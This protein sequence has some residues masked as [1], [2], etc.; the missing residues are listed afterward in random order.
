MRGRRD[1][2][3]QWLRHDAGI[4]DR[5]LGACARHGG[6]RSRRHPRRRDGARHRRSS[7]QSYASDCWSAAPLTSPA[8]LEDDAPFRSYRGG[9]WT[10]TQL[11]TFRQRAPGEEKAS[12]LDPYG[13]S[14]GF[15]VGF[16]CVYPA[17]HP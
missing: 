6:G 13:D 9:A 12:G 5:D 15:D 2:A 10:G 8:C 14:L 11:M 17:P 4:D 7:G 3:D 16:R 1:L